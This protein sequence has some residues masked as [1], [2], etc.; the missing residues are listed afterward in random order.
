MLG[1]V[2]DRVVKPFNL[3]A[4]LQKK[5]CLLVFMRLGSYLVFTSTPIHPIPLFFSSFSR[6]D[7]TH[8]PGVEYGK[9]S[10]LHTFTA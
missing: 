2:S 4:L 9:L 6:S 1:H 7:A 8:S 10:D 5:E 3:A